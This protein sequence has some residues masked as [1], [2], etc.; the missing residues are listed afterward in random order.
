MSIS[1]SSRSVFRHPRPWSV[2]LLALGVLTNAGLN[3][4]RL[5]LAFTQWSFING[6]GGVPPLYLAVS[7]LIWAAP[8]WLLAWGLWRGS[9]WA[10][11][12]ARIFVTAFLL[13]FWFER[14]FLFEQ[15]QLSWPE[16]GFFLLMVTIVVLVFVFWSTA[17]MKAKRF[18]GEFNE[19]TS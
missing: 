14:L 8:A 16:N 7:G 9:G 17:N 19:R 15:N 1:Q 6:L 10:A 13:F 18:F 5:A 2:T 3:T 4:T 11:R 12:A